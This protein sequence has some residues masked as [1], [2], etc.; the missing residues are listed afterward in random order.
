MIQAVGLHKMFGEKTILNG[1]DIRIKKGE[2]FGL[3]G[4]SGAG[5]TT[6]IKLLT[7]QISPEKGN[8]QILGKEVHL[9][10][11]KDKKQIGIMM[12]AFGV[13]ER[14]SCYDNL[15]VF[16][17]IYGINK[18]GII[19]A[20]AEVGLG[21]AIRRPAS[22]L[23]K[24]MRNRLLLARVFMQSPQILFLDEPTS[25]LDPASTEEIHKLIEKKKKEGCTIFLTTHN[26][27]EAYKLCDK[28]ALLSEGTFVEEGTPEEICRKHN[29]NQIIGVRLKDGKT[30]QFTDGQVEELCSLLREKQIETIHSSEPNLETVFMKIT[31]KELNR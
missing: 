11:G 7:G 10:N 28:I 16:A 13:Y 18:T 24:G 8:I 5:K 17:K 19:D 23:S 22:K 1:I 12:D 26:M 20:L 9:L 15:E 27:Q 21:E 4:P 6:I 14:F 3:L 30:R 25:G 2:I 31:G 29:T